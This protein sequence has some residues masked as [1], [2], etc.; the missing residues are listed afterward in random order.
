MGVTRQIKVGI[1]TAPKIEFEQRE[2]T[3]VLKN[4]RIG[5]GFHWDRYEDQEFAGTLEIR[6]P[7]GDQHAR[8]GG[9]PLFGHQ[10]GDERQQSDGTA[11][12]ACSHQPFMGAPCY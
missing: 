7:N 2:N 1:L 4:V 12:S 11:Q 8:T 3:F 6:H 10:F 9:L 5:I